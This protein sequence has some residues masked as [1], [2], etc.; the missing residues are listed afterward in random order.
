MPG[1]GAE[2]FLRAFGVDT[3]EMGIGR[4]GGEFPREIRTNASFEEAR[5]RG[6]LEDALHFNLGRVSR[7]GAEARR[8]TR[9][10]LFG[11]FMRCGYIACNPLTGGRATELCR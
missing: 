8:K 7:K 3:L 10:S 5:L 11:I 1:N 6:R 4:R 2:K 9:S